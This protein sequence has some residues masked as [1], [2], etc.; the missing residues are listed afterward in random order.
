MKC[1]GVVMELNEQDWTRDPY[2]K[3]VEEL[4]SLIRPVSTVDETRVLLEVRY[5][6]HVVLQIVP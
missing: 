3:S 4:K 6:G 5:K 2:V 1:I